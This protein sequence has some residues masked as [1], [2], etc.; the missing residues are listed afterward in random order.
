VLQRRETKEKCIAVLKLSIY[1]YY[2]YVSIIIDINNLPNMS[3]TSN[4]RRPYTIT[5]L[6]QAHC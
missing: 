3:S 2:K 1:M 5:C 6:N 4:E